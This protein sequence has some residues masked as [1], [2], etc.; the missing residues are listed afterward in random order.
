MVKEGLEMKFLGLLTCCFLAFGCYL[1]AENDVVYYVDPIDNPNIVSIVASAAPSSTVYV[2]KGEYKITS[3]LA[4]AN[5][6][7]IIGA[8]GKYEDV[9]INAQGK[10][11]VILANKG[12]NYISGLTLINGYLNPTK[13]ANKTQGVGIDLRSGG[14]VTN[15]RITACFGGNYINGVGIYLSNAACYDVLIDHC[16]HSAPIQSKAHLSEG[17]IV[18]VKGSSVIDRARVV[19]NTIEYGTYTRD[20]NWGGVLSIANTGSTYASSCIVRNCEIAHN[21]FEN[22]ERKGLSTTFGPIGVSVGAGILENC[23]IVSNAVLV[24]ESDVIDGTT[25]PE[26]AFGVVIYP[27]NNATVSNCHIA[28]NFYKGFLR[29]YSTIINN[30][31]NAS[32]HKRFVYCCTYP[33]NANL[34]NSCVITSDS[35]YRVDERGHVRIEKKSP[36]IGAGQLQSWMAEAKD[37]YGKLRVRSGSVDIG[38]VEYI[39]DTSFFMVR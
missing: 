3:S 13:A 22:Y 30:A 11:R 17:Y 34:P 14:V 25:A 6:V 18:S 7:R 19:W 9:I 28:D 29:N 15:C 2:A 10:C 36:L 20:E 24:T 26:G 31:S 37:V 32:Y 23:T 33:A 12:N 27:S 35:K 4:P 8:T 5:G 38:A 21:V 16:T 39:P 1:Y